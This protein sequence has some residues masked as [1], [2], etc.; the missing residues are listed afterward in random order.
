MDTGGEEVGISDLSPES[1]TMADV[2]VDIR[3]HTLVLLLDI[4]DELHVLLF[5]LRCTQFRLCFG[6]IRSL[7]C[8]LLCL[9]RIGFGFGFRFIRSS[10]GFCLVSIRFR[11][12]LRF[13]GVGLCL[14]L[15]RVSFRFGFGFIGRCF[16]FRFRSSSL[17]LFLLLLRSC[18]RLLFLFLRFGLCL[19]IHGISSRYGVVHY[20]CYRSY[21]SQTHC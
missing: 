3:Q 9:L 15:I 8:L 13:V 11:F 18:F 1:E 5:L 21:Y 14:R 17:L 10:L 19:V 4:R 7:L 2:T 6:L 16:L 20:G 12:R